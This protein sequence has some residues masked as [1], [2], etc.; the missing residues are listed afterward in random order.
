MG[1]IPEHQLSRRAKDYWQVDGLPL[2]VGGAAYLAAIGMFAGVLYLGTHHFANAFLE[3][4]AKICAGFAVL[5]GFFWVIAALIWLEMNWEDI[6]EWFKIRL[7]Y[8]RTGYVAPP[9]YWQN[10]PKLAAPPQESPLC[11]WLTV[12]GS[13]WFWLLIS[14]IF[15]SP[16]WDWEPPKLV[17]GILL[18]LL[19]T[20]R[21]LRYG[22]Y[23][24]TP[25]A[26]NSQAI[27]SFG[28]L[29][30]VRSVLNSVW[31]WAFVA[32]LLPAPSA[33]VRP[34]LLAGVAIGVLL[35]VIPRLAAA[36]SISRIGLSLCGVI[37]IILALKNSLT[38]N[39]LALIL[40]GFYATLTGGVR[41]FRYLRANSSLPS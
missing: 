7:T 18:L 36:T 2:L 23:P 27:K 13:L 15:H 3:S 1:A 22:L 4:L 26:E 41:L 20:I 34:W 12:F 5:T 6:I 28:V 16:F 8:P 10:E 33:A 39:I 17:T 14:V 31:V 35:A 11:R 40:P 24:E 21:G 19:L 25:T 37:C 9:S 29:R 32:R 38:A 30:F